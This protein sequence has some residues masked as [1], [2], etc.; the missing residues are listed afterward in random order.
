MG[1]LHWLARSLLG[2]Q[3]CCALPAL[4]ALLSWTIAF[5]A[6]GIGASCWKEGHK[7]APSW[8][9]TKSVRLASGTGPPC[10]FAGLEEKFSISAD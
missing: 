5:D 9:F 3:D 1:A 10:F 2:V 6:S 7:P 8:V 4:H